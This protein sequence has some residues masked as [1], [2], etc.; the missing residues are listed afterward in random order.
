[1]VFAVVA[2]TLAACG[3]PGMGSGESTKEVA[4]RTSVTPVRAVTV[5]SDNLRASRSVTVTLEATTDSQI[6]AGASGT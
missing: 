5:K 3:R 1:M 4:P 2:L 6:A